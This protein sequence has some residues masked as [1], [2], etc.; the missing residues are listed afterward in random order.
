MCELAIFD[1][2][3]RFPET[4]TTVR[5]LT[6]LS[7]LRPPRHNEMSSSGSVKPLPRILMLHGWCQ[8]GAIFRQK[9]SVWTRK[10]KGLAELVYVTS[11]LVVPPHKIAESTQPPV[12]PDAV[13]STARVV[14]VHNPDDDAAA[15]AAAGIASLMRRTVNTAEA[16]PSPAAESSLAAASTAIA[17][18]TSAGAGTPVGDA[19][20]KDADVSEDVAARDAR[21]W[22]FYNE[23]D[24]ADISD[25]LARFRRDYYSWGASR[26]FI[27]EVWRS[28]GPFDAI[29]GFSQGAVATHILLADIAA[30]TKGDTSALPDETS[31][32]SGHP[33]RC[34]VFVCGFPSCASMRQ[35]EGALLSTPS[36]HCVATGDTLVPP[37]LQE[38]LSTCFADSTLLRFDRGHSMPQRAGDLDTIISF[39]AKHVDLPTKGRKGSSGK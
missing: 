1:L 26:A 11:P 15:A 25:Y 29:V 7:F 20:D 28:Q 3:H 5:A 39:M 22:F 14:L 31:I 10:F 13:V 36:L 16:C 34:A 23:L 27:A 6:K 35:H 33:P 4:N 12:V 17:C 18:D 9:T 32:L 19:D 37:H 2:P 38:E 8:N 30:Y 21:G 24:P